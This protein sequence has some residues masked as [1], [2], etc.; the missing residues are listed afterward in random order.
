MTN[1]FLP[2]SGPSASRI[3]TAAT[4]SSGSAIR[5]GPYSPHAISPSLGPTMAMPSPLRVAKL[6]LVAACSHIRTFIAGAIKT[7]VSV[8]NNKVEAR[9]FAN[10]CAIFA[11]KSAVAGATT[12]KSATR[13]SWIWPISASSP[14]S[15]R[16]RKTL[17]PAKA[18][19]DKGVTNSS[20]AR[21]KTGVTTAPRSRRRR[22]R[23]SDLNAAM[24]PPM[25]S[26]MCFPASMIRPFMVCLSGDHK[27]GRTNLPAPA[28][29]LTQSHQEMKHLLRLT[30][31]RLAHLAKGG[32]LQLAHALF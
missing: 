21:V 26:R 20:P 2:F 15:N 17:L 23:S 1:T 14:K 22:I 28:R 18:D 10:P 13:L 24:P 12:T 7:G 32:C 9:S 6:R 25:I 19:T 8:A 11:I 31:K 27:T 5:P 16:S 29:S 3:S 4:I 30:F